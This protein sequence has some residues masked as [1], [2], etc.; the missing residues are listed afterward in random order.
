MD[1]VFAV[2]ASPAAPIAMIAAV[3]WAP[4][5]GFPTWNAISRGRFAVT[6]AVGAAIGGV[7]FIAAQHLAALGAG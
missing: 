6:S 5:T 2:L 3:A 1:R 7:A 4:V